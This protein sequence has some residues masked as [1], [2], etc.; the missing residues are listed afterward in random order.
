L[1]DASNFAVL[2]EGKGG[3]TLNFNNAS[4]FGNIGTG[5][6]DSS[7]GCVGNCVITGAID[8]SAPNTGQFSNSGATINGGENYGLAN[9]QN[10]LNAL[11]SLSQTLGLEGRQV[12]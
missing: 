2:Y 8:F 1:D 4:I 7:G 9:V 11:N 6:F 10:D 3:N 5:K 12:K